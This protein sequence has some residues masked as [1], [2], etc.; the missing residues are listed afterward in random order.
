MKR[1]STILA[2][3]L[4]GAFLLSQSP[5]SAKTLDSAND[6]GIPEK[7]G[8]YDVPG[9]SKMK[10]QIFVHYPK[11]IKMFFVKKPVFVCKLDDP[12]S[13]AIVGKIGW[14]LPST[15]SYT[16]NSSGV[17]ASVGGKNL[18]TI[19]SN[20]FGQWTSAI[21]GKVNIS[22]TTSNTTANKAKYDGKNIIAWG[23]TSASALAVTYT[24][25]YTS[26]K[27]VADVDTIMNKKYSWSWTAYN[28]SNLCA[29]VNTYDAQN[30]LTHELGHWYGLY[31]HYTDNFANNT[32]FGYGST[33][34]IKKDT[35]TAGDKTG[36]NMIY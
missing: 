18:P 36:V 5:V 32:M 29:V 33:A 9:N 2:A 1:S 31:D 15:W 4:V 26:T 8:I 14:K 23:Q 25:Y 6:L 17:P 19:A 10:V 3:L 24:W 11:A 7:N 13:N 22:K 16:L 20:A 27:M 34:E 12:G 21:N 30:I 35:L 28:S